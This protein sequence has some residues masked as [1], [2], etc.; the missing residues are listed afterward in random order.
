MEIKPKTMITMKILTD[1]LVYPPQ[2]DPRRLPCFLTSD[3]CLLISVR[4]PLS[5]TSASGGSGKGLSRGL[6]IMRNK[7]N[8]QKSQLSVT[9]DMIRTYND[10]QSKKRKKNKPKTHQKRT[11]NEQKTNKKRTKTN[12]NEQNS[13]IFFLHPAQNR[14]QYSQVC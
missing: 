13:T 1:N 6:L 3:I 11:K 5:I 10:N 9:L 7:P 2:A 12:E 4:C 14:L 8:F